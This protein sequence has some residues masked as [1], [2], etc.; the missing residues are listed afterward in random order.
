MP[1]MTY[2]NEHGESISYEGKVAIEHTRRE[3]EHFWKKGIQVLSYYVGSWGGAKD[4]FQRMYGK[5][6]TYID[7]NNLNQLAITLNK[8]FMRRYKV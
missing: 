7:V 3:I 4:S 1:G 2:V 6:A 8:K 5:D